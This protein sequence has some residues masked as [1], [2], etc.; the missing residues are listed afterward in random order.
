MT[1]FRLAPGAVEDGL[2]MIAEEG[3]QGSLLPRTQTRSRLYEVLE[4]GAYA[5]FDGSVFDFALPPGS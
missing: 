4:Y 3:T 5:A 1:F 2:R